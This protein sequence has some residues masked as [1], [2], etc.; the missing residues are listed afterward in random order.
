MVMVVVRPRCWSE[1]DSGGVAEHGT[2]QPCSDARS[3]SRC[4]GPWGGTSTAPWD[5]R[6]S[7]QAHTSCGVA[8]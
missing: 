5:R 3:L 8:R 1:K 2:G 7:L 6:V 4:W